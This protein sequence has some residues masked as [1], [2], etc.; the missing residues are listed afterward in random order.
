ME[1]LIKGARIIDCSQDFTGDV[2]IKN[3]LIDEIGRNLVKDCDVIDGEGLMLLPSFV[4]LHSHF[5]DP[6]LTYKEDIESGSRAA[7]KGG[8]TGVNLMANTKP[9][10]SSMEIFNYVVEKA[11]KIGLVDVMQTISITK[12]LEG[13]DISHLDK[14]TSPAR[15]ISDDGKGVLKDK[16]MLEAMKKAAKMGFVVM[17][18]A[19]NGEITSYDTRLSEDIMT[20]RDICLAKHTGCHLHMS[21]VSTIQSMTE[22]IRAKKD[23]YNVTCEVTPH[24]IALTGEIEYR[25]NPSLR[26]KEDTDFLVNAIKEGWIDAI[27]TDH[28]PHSAEDKLKGSPGMVGIETAFSVCFTRLVKEGHI[29]INKLSEIMS[30]NPSK[31]IGFNKGEIKIGFDGDVVLVD[32][33]KKIKVD[34]N[35]FASKGKNTPFD[36]MELYGDIVMT[37]KG[38]KVVY[39]REGL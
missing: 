30:R 36:G 38:G 4:D 9:V 6:G 1:V 20:V 28:A 35:S 23:G 21:H 34:A 17:S 19:E 10:C 11:K 29:T 31:I 2:Y 37:I 5:R 27:S 25:V 39:S 14:I 16:V 7:V 26:E 12:D 13:E 22:I 15:S 32:I 3:G 33:D 24:H 8:F 18:H